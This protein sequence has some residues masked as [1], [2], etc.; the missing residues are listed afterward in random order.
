VTDSQAE[1]ELS[2]LLDR[3]IGCPLIARERTALVS[4]EQNPAISASTSMLGIYVLP[5]NHSHSGH[6]VPKLSRRILAQTERHA[7]DLCITVP[8]QGVADHMRGGVLVVC[9]DPF[10]NVTTYSSGQRLGRPRPLGGRLREGEFARK[11]RLGDW[12]VVLVLE[13]GGHE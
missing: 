4:E 2:T 10:A 9:E 8:G 6:V 12:G 5:D 11:I 1:L 7:M 13:V 3:F